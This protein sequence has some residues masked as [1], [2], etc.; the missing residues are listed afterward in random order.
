MQRAGNR[1]LLVDGSRW[2]PERVTTLRRMWPTHSAAEIA[3]ELEHG[4]TRMAVIGKAHR[5]N[6]PMKCPSYATYGGKRK[7][8]RT[9]AK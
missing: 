7:T 2:T 8:A 6:L 9:T 3:A 4:F 1:Y 5:L